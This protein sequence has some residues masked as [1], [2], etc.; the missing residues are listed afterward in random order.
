MDHDKHQNS[1]SAEML[2]LL[3]CVGEPVFGQIFICC[4]WNFSYFLDGGPQTPSSIF[5]ILHKM[6][7]LIH[8]LLNNSIVITISA[9]LTVQHFNQVKNQQYCRI[10]AWRMWYLYREF[11]FLR[12]P[13]IQGQWSFQANKINLFYASCGKKHDPHFY[14]I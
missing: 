2:L 8:Q 5:T 14:Y 10:A 9:I 1:K 6:L 13:L 12:V 11:W 3:Q 7:S 4:I